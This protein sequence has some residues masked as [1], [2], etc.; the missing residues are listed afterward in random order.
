MFL[1]RPRVA[2][3]APTIDS[4]GNPIEELVWKHAAGHGSHA[5]GGG[6]CRLL[7][8]SGLEHTASP[9]SRCSP[10]PSCWRARLS[11]TLRG[12]GTSRSSG[13]LGR[14]RNKAR[15]CS[16]PSAGRNK[17]LPVIRPSPP[18]C[19]PRHAFPCLHCAYF[20]RQTCRFAGAVVSLVMSRSGVRLPTSAF[21]LAPRANAD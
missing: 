19:R 12:T 17:G 4:V 5:A 13:R 21:S 3:R 20:S 18:P 8:L 16:S 10:W 2:D 11:T 6:C 1:D 9:V 15:P 7:S 14:F